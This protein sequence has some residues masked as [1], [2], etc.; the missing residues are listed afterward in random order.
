MMETNN[1]KRKEELQN[2]LEK[3][4]ELKNEAIKSQQYEVAVNLRE[5]QREVEIA[6]KEI[7]VEELK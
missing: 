6:L 5:K 1:V 2:E 4:K 3:L 7:E